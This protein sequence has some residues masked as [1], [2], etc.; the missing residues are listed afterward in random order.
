M[1][2]VDTAV[3]SIEGKAQRVENRTVDRRETGPWE[4]LNPPNHSISSSYVNIRSLNRQRRRLYMSERAHRRGL[5]VP[6]SRRSKQS[7]PHTSPSPSPS[8]SRRSAPPRRSTSKRPGPVK[9]LKRCSSEPLLCDDRGAGGSPTTR[10]TNQ[11]VLGLQRPQTCN[12]V[13][14]SSPSLMIPGISALSSEVNSSKFFPSFSR[15]KKSALKFKNT[16]S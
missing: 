13:F 14:A 10:D 4:S 15:K 3:A 2:V 12:D 1:S 9:I 16:A 7:L 6:A 5:P 11:M 8:P